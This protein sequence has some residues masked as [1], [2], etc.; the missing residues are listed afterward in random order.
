MFWHIIFRELTHIASAP[1]IVLMLVF[2]MA[3]VQRKKHF[4]WL[5]VKPLPTVMLCALLVLP[6]AFAREPADVAAG[7]PAYKSYIDMPVWAIACAAMPWV[8]VR[9]HKWW[10]ELE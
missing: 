7:D 3:W 6:F 4:P 1:G 2:L 5:P 8:L 9:L 10:D